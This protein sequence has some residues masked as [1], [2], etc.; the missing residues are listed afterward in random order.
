MRSRDVGFKRGKRRYQ[1]ESQRGCDAENRRAVRSVCAPPLVL[2]RKRTCATTPLGSAASAAS[3]PMTSIPI[4]AIFHEKSE[5]RSEKNPKKR[6]PFWAECRRCGGKS[7]I[8]LRNSVEERERETERGR[9]REGEREEE[10]ERKGERERERAKQSGEGRAAAEGRPRPLAPLQVNFFVCAFLR[11]HGGD[12]DDTAAGELDTA[13]GDGGD[14]G[15]EAA[16]R[17]RGAAACSGAT[18]CR[19]SCASGTPR[20]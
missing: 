4:R 16:G 5:N 6:F 14:L 9:R 15:C 18:A 2:L 3:A 10:E 8:S 12:G 7:S 20:L 19:A 1:A 13:A 17:A 11:R